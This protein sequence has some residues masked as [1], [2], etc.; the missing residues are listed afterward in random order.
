[1]AKKKKN[2]EKSLDIHLSILAYGN[3]NNLYVRG[4]I[5]KSNN[6]V[7]KIELCCFF[8]SGEAYYTKIKKYDK[9]L[10]AE[11]NCLNKL[12]NKLYDLYEFNL[13]NKFDV[14]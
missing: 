7:A 11:S 14:R 9:V 10:Y 3:R 13:I 4:N 1:M 6:K 5:S 8:E 12:K 2:K